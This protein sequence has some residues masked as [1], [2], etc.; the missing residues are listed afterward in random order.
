MNRCD[1]SG[2]FVREVLGE[3]GPYETPA[4]DCDGCAACMKMLT[5]LQPWASLVALQVKQIETRPWSTPFRGPVAIHAGKRRLNHGHFY[6]L[7][8]KALNNDQI[9]K[10]QELLI[11]DMT[12]P[13]GAV[14]AIADM[15]DVIPILTKL[16]GFDGDRACIVDTPADCVRIWSRQQFAG[17]PAWVS[18][19]GHAEIPFGDYSTTTQRYAWLFAN[20]RALKNP[21]PAKGFQ[22]LRDCPAEV[23][24]QIQAQLVAA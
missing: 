6:L 1:G 16:D 13:F 5:L 14:V 18:S 22:G 11:R 12:V 21:V 24:D 17:H 15:V 8:R 4:G 9:T 23:A 10:E 7:A 3:G 2:T 20:V 19:I